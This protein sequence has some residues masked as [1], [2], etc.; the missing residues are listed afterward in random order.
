VDVTWRE[1]ADAAGALDPDGATVALAAQ[2][3]ADAFAVLV[4]RH[5]H[6][7]VNLIRGLGANA[8]DAEDI[9]QDAFVRAYRSLGRFR[10]ASRFKT[11]LVQIAINVARTHWTKT[12]ARGEAPMDSSRDDERAGGSAGR[13]I[14]R[15]FEAA[16]LAR[17]A[18]DRALATLPLELREA[19]VLRDL[20]GFD[21]KEI[22]AL[23][24]VPI[25][26]VESRIFRGR[27]R[28]RAS[29]TQLKEPRS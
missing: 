19:V 12:Q 2:G 4:R 22:A 16:V 14:T 13:P 10:G 9:A 6:A 29:L 1:P 20:E 28:L 15:G 11:W 8:A 7:L 18:I 3:D 5:Q 27:E 17:D 21:Y 24:A 25:G 23:L 26:T